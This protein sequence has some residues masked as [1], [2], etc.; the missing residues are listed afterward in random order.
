[1]EHLQ[2]HRVIL[3]PF[4]PADAAEAFACITDRLT[5][6]LA[7]DPPQTIHEFHP[8]WEGWIKAARAGTDLH[9]TARL[10][11]T[12]E[13]L[14]LLGLHDIP[15]GQ[16]EIGIWLR[17]EAQGQGHG[18]DMVVALIR[19]ATARYA[20]PW[21]RYPVAVENRPSR[22]IAEKLG[23]TI[24]GRYRTQKYDGVI[25]AIPPIG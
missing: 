4:N 17:D 14:G 12:D 20:P 25:Y 1:M 15:S 22:R 16:P 11:E 6:Y 7:W 13:F 19:R 21:F 9:F 3:R 10:P 5:R 23:G 2:T 24:I 18:H 8:V